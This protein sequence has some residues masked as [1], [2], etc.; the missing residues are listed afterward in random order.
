MAEEEVKQ[1]SWLTFLTLSYYQSYFDVTTH[2]VF[3][4][5][6]AGM[7]PLRLKLVESLH[8]N[9]DLYGPFWLAMT[10]ILSTAI[11]GNIANLIE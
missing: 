9:P 6:I 5:I 1:S 10:L 11:S 8:P 2:Q 3:E 7:F 4:R